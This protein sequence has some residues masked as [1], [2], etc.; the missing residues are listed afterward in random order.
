[1][2]TGREFGAQLEAMIRKSFRA[3]AAARRDIENG[4]YDFASSR[5]YYAAFYAMEAIL[6]TKEL[7]FSKHGS[8]IGAFNQ[9]FIKPGVFP[10]DFSR[11]ISKLFRERQVGD[12]EFDV[13]ITREDAEEDIDIAETMTGAIVGYL[14]QGG[15]VQL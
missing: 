12:Y 8:V 11:L 4:D 2:G 14:T 1:M 10:K 9:H 6:L 13:S 3:I 5:A 7:S 15:F